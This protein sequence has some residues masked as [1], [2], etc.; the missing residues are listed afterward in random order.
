MFDLHLMSMEIP[1]GLTIRA[2]RCLSRC[3][4]PFQEKHMLRSLAVGLILAAAILPGCVVVGGTNS[5]PR[6]TSGQE[7]IDLKAAFDKGAITQAEYDRK[8]AE[9]LAERK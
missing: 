2:L 5:A 7:L 4:F 8:K 9:I 6:P 3:H 1:I